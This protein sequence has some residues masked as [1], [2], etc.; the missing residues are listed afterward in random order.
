[1][2]NYINASEEQPL[3]T[4]TGT[5]VDSGAAEQSNTLPPTTITTVSIVSIN[6]YSTATTTF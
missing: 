4:P 3:M 1:M 6:T 2:V 5:I